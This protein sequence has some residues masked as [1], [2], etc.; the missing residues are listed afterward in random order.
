M[1]EISRLLSFVLS[2]LTVVAFV[3]VVWTG[4]WKLEQ[5]RIEARE[6]AAKEAA[7]LRET[8]KKEATDAVT[9]KDTLLQAIREEQL[10]VLREKALLARK[11][12][13][14]EVDLR[15]EIHTRRQVQ[16]YCR[17]LQAFIRGKGFE[18]P[19]SEEE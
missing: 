6:A 13:E 17:Q 11:L 7:E 5:A 19:P 10:Q 2:A 18:P 14:L 1:E 9:I 12:A 3:V 4:R 16:A 15:S 8:I